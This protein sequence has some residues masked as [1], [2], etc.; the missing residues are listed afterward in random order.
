MEA[1]ILKGPT[2][3][4]ALADKISEM[5][6]AIARLSLLHAHDELFLLRNALAMPKLLHILRT[7]RCTGN[8]LLKVFDDTLRKGLT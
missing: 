8:K 2:V 1:P 5:E 7:A 6:R 3:D 4:K